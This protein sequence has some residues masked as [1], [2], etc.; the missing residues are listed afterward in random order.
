[1]KIFGND[2]K[3]LNSGK[4]LVSDLL[5]RKTS[6]EEKAKTRLKKRKISKTGMSSMMTSNIMMEE[7]LQNHYYGVKSPY[8]ISHEFN[9]LASD[10]DMYMTIP[11]A[12]ANTTQFL[13]SDH[14]KTRHGIQAHE[15]AISYVAD[16]SS[17][18]EDN[19]NNLNSPST[20]EFVDNICVTGG[21]MKG[22]VNSNNLKLLSSYKDLNTL[23]QFLSQFYKQK[24]IIQ[25][26]R[27]MI[28]CLQQQIEDL[29]KYYKAP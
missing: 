7:M 2:K 25:E 24:D 18:F 22:I 5:R 6:T 1:M 21:S 23:K 17:F 26:Q 9:N 11:K 19:M 20:N 28:E 13:S 16:Y 14:K 3:L 4:K 10:C 12:P 8:N 15:D 29:R 27:S